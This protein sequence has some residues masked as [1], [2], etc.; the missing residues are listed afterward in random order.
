MG[1]VRK[2]VI[3]GLIGVAALAGAGL[4][5]V[6]LAP[7]DP[8]VWHVDPLTTARTGKPNDVLA[9]PADAPGAEIETPPQPQEPAALIAA[10]DAIAAE[11]GAVRLDDRSDPARATWVVR[12]AWVGYPD[13]VSA[14][15]WVGPDGATRF[16]LYSRSRFG[17]S[18]LGVNRQRVEAWLA[19]LAGA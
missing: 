12:S 17:H 3:A 14:R 4:A 2:I 13:Y 5:Y 11:A 16:A 6:R 9:A 1:S 15:A 18:D 10:L 8:A 19:A 7:S